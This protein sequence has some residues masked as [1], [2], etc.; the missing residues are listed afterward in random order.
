MFRRGMHSP[1]LA[2]FEQAI[3]GRMLFVVERDNTLVVYGRDGCVV[4]GFNRVQAPIP[5]VQTPTKC[6]QCYSSQGVGKQ[7]GGK[8]SFS[9]QL[10]EKKREREEASLPTTQSKTMEKDVEPNRKS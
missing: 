3:G 6:K 8:L 4:E 2:E 10:E 1:V 9:K 5:L 7:R